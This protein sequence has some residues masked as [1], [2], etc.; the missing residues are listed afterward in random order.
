VREGKLLNLDSKRKQ[1]LPPGGEVSS[2]SLL[3]DYLPID[4]IGW[5][6]RTR[7]WE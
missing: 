4:G 2:L 3:S 5:G 7:T 1:K 6:A